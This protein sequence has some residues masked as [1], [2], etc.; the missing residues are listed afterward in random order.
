MTNREREEY[1]QHV[2]GHCNL[3]VCDHEATTAQPRQEDER[4]PL[5]DGNA[6][7]RVLPCA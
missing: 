7:A 1:H 6:R 4:E 2:A 3:L 5:G